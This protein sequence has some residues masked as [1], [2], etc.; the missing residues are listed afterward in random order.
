MR[1][2]VE[3]VDELETGIAMAVRFV[4]EEG[5]LVRYSVVL[6]AAESG[7]FRAVRVFDNSHG[8]HDMHRYTRGGEKLAAEVFH[9]GSA[10]EA[11]N[12]ALRLVRSRWRGM[13]EA[14]RA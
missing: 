3:Y 7:E 13:V 4:T 5:D 11:M 1:Q 14:W 6:L 10:S 2:L 12:A 8:P 9:R